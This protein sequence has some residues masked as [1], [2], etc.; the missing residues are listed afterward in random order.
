MNSILK[1]ENISKVYH[2]KSGEI[3]AVKDITFQVKEGEFISIIGPS[4]CGKSTI[5]SILSG[6]E[7]ESSGNVVCDHYSIGYMLQTDALFPWLTILDNALLGLKMK[8]QNLQWL[9]FKRKEIN[10]ETRQGYRRKKVLK[11]WV[12]NAL[13][14]LLGFIVGIAITQLFTIKKTYETPAGSYTCRGGIIQ[15]CTGS[16]EVADYLGV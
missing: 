15:V 6:L 3:E 12:K 5:L 16:K 11:K 1:L 2:T 13:W 8:K 4:G 10:M 9:L 7:K 14:F